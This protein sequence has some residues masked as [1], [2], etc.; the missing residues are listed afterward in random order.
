MKHI[1]GDNKNGFEIRNVVFRK[2][3]P[4]AFES[5]VS[6]LNTAD[7]APRLIEGEHS[8]LEGVKSTGQFEEAA[9]AASTLWNIAHK[10]ELTDLQELIY[11]K[12]EVQTPLAA[13]SLLMMTRMVF[14]NSP[15][16]AKIDGKMRKMLKLDVA[17][18]LHEILQEEPFL[19]SRLVKSDVDLA[20]YIFQYQVDHPWEE[21]PEH[22]SE[23]DG[24]D[25]E[26]DDE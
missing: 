10:L 11:R 20:N 16:N 9:D 22:L 25:A 13:N 1:T 24:D 21:P 8:H 5:L 12:I 4:A 23:D 18:R 19:F 7:Y 17:A 6:W 15:T 2:L 26:D 14:W 3:N